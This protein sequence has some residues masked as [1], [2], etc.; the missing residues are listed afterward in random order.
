MRLIVIVCAY[1]LTWAFNNFLWK[2]KNQNFE[3]EYF[4]AASKHHSTIY[5]CSYLF[6]TKRLSPVNMHS[7]LVFKIHKCVWNGSF[8]WCWICN[9][10]IRFFRNFPSWLCSKT[11]SS[12]RKFIYD[13]F[14]GTYC[15]YMDLKTCIKKLKNLHKNLEDH[16][17]NWAIKN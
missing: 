17:N 3:C 7:P 8:F 9:I 1:S 6:L 14:F 16:N 5:S 12:D 4:Q 10:S 2:I 15:R 11:F 13:Y